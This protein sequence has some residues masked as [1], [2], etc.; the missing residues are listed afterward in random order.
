MATR[1]ELR[2]RLARKVAERN[3][4][5]RDMQRGPDTAAARQSLSQLRESRD[6]YRGMSSDLQNSGIA[7]RVAE[8]AAARR[9]AAGSLSPQSRERLADTRRGMDADA[10]AGLP[11]D[12][13]KIRAM[14]EI[15]RRARQEGGDPMVDVAVEGGTMRIPESEMIRRSDAMHHRGARATTLTTQKRNAARE[16][17]AELADGGKRD[18]AIKVLRDAGITD[19]RGIPPA[20]TSGGNGQTNSLTDRALAA[21]LGGAGGGGRR[22]PL[23]ATLG[24]QIA[25]VSRSGVDAPGAFFGRY[26]RPGVYGGHSGIKHGQVG[27]VAPGAAYP[28]Y[29][30]AGADSGSSDR[31]SR[32]RLAALNL[33]AA[34]ENASAQRSHEMAMGKQ[35]GEYSVAAARARGEITSQAEER[36]IKAI[37]DAQGR[38]TAPKPSEVGPAVDKA[39]ADLPDPVSLSASGV[40]VDASE[41]RANVGTAITAIESSTMSA[42][43]K[44][45]RLEA[46]KADQR[47]N[48]A[49]NP[50]VMDY[51]K[52]VFGFA[53]NPAAAITMK[54]RLGQEKA[55]LDKEIDR[56]I[57]RVR[58]GSTQ[59][60]PQGN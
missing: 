24:P 42:D 43:E 33:L 51:T 6:D 53:A 28:G 40:R 17:A 39:L 8:R 23:F 56:S 10:V 30:G 45:A 27:G 41:L 5:I 37:E 55:A 25:G 36:R 54:E 52:G 13:D 60:T 38:A 32:E 34:R 9:V 2:R 20:E 44:V 26:R 14:R 4:Q 48:A 1:E 16:K 18:A 31:P 50:D 7:R 22:Q 59:G 21:I 35:S 47:I 11:E 49:F 58:G 29:G 57:A 12:T 3:R 15:N 19:T 46:L